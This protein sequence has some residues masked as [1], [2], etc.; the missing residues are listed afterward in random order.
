[1]QAMTI[2]A[3]DI[4]RSEHEVILDVLS[5]LDSVSRPAADGFGP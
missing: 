5:A 1:M 3:T 2:K 4:L